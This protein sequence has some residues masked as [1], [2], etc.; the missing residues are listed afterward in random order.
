MLNHAAETQKVPLSPLSTKARIGRKG[1][2]PPPPSRNYRVSHFGTEMEGKGGEGSLAGRKRGEEKKKKLPLLQF[3]SLFSLF[4]SFLFSELQ[5][6]VV[7]RKVCERRGE[8][9]E[10]K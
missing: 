1:P 4:H 9:V 2:P 10:E 6:K 8:K 5:R 7:E 3:L